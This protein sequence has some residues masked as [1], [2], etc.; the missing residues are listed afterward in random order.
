MAEVNRLVDDY[1]RVKDDLEP[2]PARQLLERARDG[3][4]TIL[5][6]RPAEEFAAGHLPGAV[7]ITLDELEQNLE[8]LQSS[9]EIIAYCRGPHCVLA[10]D[11][12]AKLREQGINARRLEG[13]FPEW[14]MEGYSVEV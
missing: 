3:L 4:V 12:V 5:D 6:V 9:D 2:I 7:N 10:F 11:A 14:K 1:L 8:Q 13:G